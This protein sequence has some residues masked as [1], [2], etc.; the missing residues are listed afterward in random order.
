VN[1]IVKLADRIL[2]AAKDKKRLLVAIAGPPASGKSTLSDSLTTTLKAHT[3]VAVIAMDGFHF[4]NAILVERNLLHRKGAPNTFDV[5]GLNLLLQATKNQTTEILTAPVFDRERDLSI[6]CATTIQPED[7]IIIVEGNY[8]LCDV[9]PWQAL[10]TLFDLTISVEVPR[11]VLEQRLIKR[12][13]DNNH[14]EAQAKSRTHD[15]DLPNTDY[16]LQNTLTTD[17]VI[18]QS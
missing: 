10:S 6:A 15:N 1:D 14:T 5:S 11:D 3:S 2:D 12:W 8:L 13:L 7:H 17:I 9:P 4:D 18:Q 16:V